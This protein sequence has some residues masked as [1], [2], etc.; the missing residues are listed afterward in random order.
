MSRVIEM[1]GREIK[2]TERV[3]EREKGEKGREKDQVTKRER[4]REAKSGENIERVKCEGNIQEM[5]G[6]R[7]TEKA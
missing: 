7:E 5:A 4:R 2:K 3:C 6:Q 1:G